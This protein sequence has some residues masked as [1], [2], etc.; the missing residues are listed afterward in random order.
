MTIYTAEE[1]GSLQHDIVWLKKYA[2]KQPNISLC[3]YI[4][5]VCDIAQ[6][7]LQ[8]ITGKHPDYVVVPREPTDEMITAGFEAALTKLPPD[9]TMPSGM[10]RRNYLYTSMIQ[11]AQ[12]E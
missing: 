4:L 6:K 11:A 9:E 2:P 5:D 8:L 10:M 1:I 7:Y 12:E 3:A